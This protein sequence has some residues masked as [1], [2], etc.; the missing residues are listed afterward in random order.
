MANRRHRLPLRINES[1]PRPLFA[2]FSVWL[3]AIKKAVRSIAGIVTSDNTSRKE[4][5]IAAIVIVYLTD[6]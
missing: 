6:E 2:R 5:L 4:R 3:I 1:T